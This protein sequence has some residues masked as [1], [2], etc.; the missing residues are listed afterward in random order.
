METDGIS[1]PQ[2]NEDLTQITLDEL[3]EKAY[4]YDRHRLAHNEK[5]K[6][7][8]LKYPEAYK[9]RATKLATKRYWRL[10]GYEITETGEK[11]RIQEL[12]ENPENQEIPVL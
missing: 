10:K 2:N 1:T 7:Y 11:I 12:Q 4:K 8:R 3:L 9:E 6:R 5:M